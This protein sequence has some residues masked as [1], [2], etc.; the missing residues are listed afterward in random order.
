MD[1]LVANLVSDLEFMAVIA[2]AVIAFFIRPDFGWVGDSVHFA[3]HW[4]VHFV[5]LSSS[6]RRNR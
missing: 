3:T 5:S 2:D 6:S 4:T 1:L